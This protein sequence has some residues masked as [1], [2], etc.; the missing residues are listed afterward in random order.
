METRA[1]VLYGLPK[2]PRIPCCSRSAPAQESILLMRSTWKG[3]T[4]MRRWNV[5]LPAFFTMYLLAA[6]RAASSASDPIC[7]F[8]KLGGWLSSQLQPALTLSPRFPQQ[9]GHSPDQVHAVRE[10]VHAIALHTRVCAR[11][12]SRVQRNAGRLSR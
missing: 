12:V 9:A 6:M 2:A 3:W 10:R 4:R 1:Q 5:S 7:S 8:S 11:G